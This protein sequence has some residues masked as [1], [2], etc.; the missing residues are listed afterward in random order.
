[1]QVINPLK[2]HKVEEVKEKEND[3]FHCLQITALLLA[4]VL[5]LTVITWNTFK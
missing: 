2:V 3:Q 1:M 4:A 5:H